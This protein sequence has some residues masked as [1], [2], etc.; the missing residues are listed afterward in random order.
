MYTF[1][2]THYNYRHKGSTQGIGH[3]IMA[4]FNVS[5]KIQF[6]KMSMMSVRLRRLELKRGRARR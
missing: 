6:I 4:M 5:S 1:I 3:V 2:S